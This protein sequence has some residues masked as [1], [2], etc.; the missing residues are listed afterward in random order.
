MADNTSCVYSSKT[1]NLSLNLYPH[2]RAREC[3]V[4]VIFLETEQVWQ[5][6]TCPQ[7]IMGH[8]FTNSSVCFD[9][10]GLSFKIFPYL[11]LEVLILIYG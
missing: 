3:R 11:Y 2:R 8:I 5:L 1:D 6:R 10:E 4:L 7:N 9:T